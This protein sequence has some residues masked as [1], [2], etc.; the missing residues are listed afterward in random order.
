[1]ASKMTVH[2]F[3]FQLDD[4]KS[5]SLLVGKGGKNLVNKIIKPSIQDF[6][7]LKDTTHQEIIDKVKKGEIKIKSLKIKFEYQDDVAEPY[8]YATWSDIEELGAANVLLIK[9]IQEKITE[10]AKSINKFI[11]I[12]K[13]DMKKEKKSEETVKVYRQN[14]YFRMN[15]DENLEIGRFIGNGGEIINAFRKKIADTLKVEKVYVNIDD[16]DKDV[17]MYRVIGDTISE[18]SDII[19]NVSYLGGTREDILKIEEMIIEFVKENSDEEEEDYDYDD[20][21][22]FDADADADD[23]DDDADDADDDGVDHAAGG[24]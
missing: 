22:D 14:F 24:W 3:K 23:K 4:K 5:I 11:K 1:M 20:Y 16:F 17:F 21:D 12:K 7:K 15:V 6:M 19:F 10:S 8:P 9:C 18:D 13:K 2:N